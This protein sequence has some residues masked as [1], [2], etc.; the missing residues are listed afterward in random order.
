MRN[1]LKRWFI[2]D[3]LQSIPFFT[4]IIYNIFSVN[5]NYNNKIQVLLLLKIIKSFKMLYFN[6][7]ISDFG[8]ILSSIEI[9]DNYSTIKLK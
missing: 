9:I 3:F 8:E 6:N 5:F 1:Y 2:I 4:L 7:T